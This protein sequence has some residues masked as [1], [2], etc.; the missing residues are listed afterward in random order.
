LPDGWRA[1]EAVPCRVE[2]HR[3]YLQRPDGSEMPWIITK[4][5]PIDKKS[6][7]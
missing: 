4:K 1:G 7:D 3:L 6:Q 5:K 2:G